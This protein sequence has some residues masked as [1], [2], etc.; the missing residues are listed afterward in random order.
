M[1]EGKHA[2]STNK[3]KRPVPMIVLLCLDGIF[4]RFLRDIQSVTQ[5]LLQHGASPKSL[6]AVRIVCSHSNTKS[7]GHG[8]ALIGATGKEKRLLSARGEPTS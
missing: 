1:P 4:Q 6:E 2:K 5:D 7:A 3:P 8:F